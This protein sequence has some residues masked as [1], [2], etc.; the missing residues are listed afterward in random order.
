MGY[1]IF[2]HGGI[3]PS[4]TVKGMEWAALPAGT[5]LQFYA[6]AGQALV[7]GVKTWEMYSKEL[8]VPWAAI[9]STGVTYNFRLEPLSAAEERELDRVSGDFPHTVLMVGKNLKGS[10][11]LCT[12]DPS[13]CPTDPRMITGQ[14]QGKT[15]HTCDGILKH[16]AGEELHWVACTGIDGFAPDVQEA[17]TA[18]R[19]EAPSEV[20][21]G[22]D[23]D[24]PVAN[25]LRYLE[26]SPAQFEA[27]FDS[28]PADERDVLTRDPGIGAW[29]AGRSFTVE[30]WAPSE[31]DLQA[32]ADV[33]Q[34]Y[35]KGLDGEE[36]TWEIGGFLVLLGPNHGYTDWVR[37]QND[38]AAGTFKVKKATFGAGK[39]VF[40]GVPPMHQ[41][42]VT[43]AVERFSE[44][45]VEFE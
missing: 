23:P 43:A 11:Q 31:G 16:Y 25:A 27:W 10:P 37:D 13:T 30:E 21:H 7:T 42:T 34:P 38:H 8:T 40:S 12:G 15:T 24:D 32:V 5:T 1:V 17:V 26:T 33:N 19:G 22:A 35:V 39:M 45:A 6:D 29:S 28:L 2:G 18:A 3:D 36:G 14:V 4:G 41:G 20:V 44:K 9:D